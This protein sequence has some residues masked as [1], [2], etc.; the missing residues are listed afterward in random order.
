[1]VAAWLVLGSKTTWLVS[2]EEYE[3]WLHWLFQTLINPVLFTFLWGGWAVQ[4]STAA[5]ILD[6]Y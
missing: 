4:S 1:M 2:E 6:L 3:L 5:S